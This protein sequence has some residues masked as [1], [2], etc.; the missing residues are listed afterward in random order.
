M[1]GALEFGKSNFDAIYQDIEIR[2]S[3][4]IFK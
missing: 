1:G 3:N 4:Q 2:I